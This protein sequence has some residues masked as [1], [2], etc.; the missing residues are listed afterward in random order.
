MSR[1]DKQAARK[2]A[3]LAARNAQIAAKPI[4]AAVVAQSAA[5]LARLA[6]ATDDDA[7]LSLLIEG[8]RHELPVDSVLPAHARAW[9]QTVRE[10]LTLAPARDLTAFRRAIEKL[11]K[12][13]AAVADHDM[14]QARVLRNALPTKWMHG[15]TGKLAQ[16]LVSGGEEAVQHA[17]LT[18][19]Q[20][21]LRALVGRGEI[22][23][24]Q[25]V[26]E[27]AGP[28]LPNAQLVV[29]EMR[30]Q[31]AQLAADVKKNAQLKDKLLQALA[32]DDFF[33]AR[34]C[35]ETLRRSLPASDEQALELQIESR[36]GPALAGKMLPPGVQKLKDAPAL[37]AIAQDRLI[38]VQDTIWFSVNL[39][40]GGLQP[41]ALPAQWPILAGP[42]C[43]L[44]GAGG[45]V[46]LIGLSLGQ[47]I[48][49]EQIP[50]QVP[51]IMRG[52]ALSE[53]LQ[54]DDLLI[55][56][57]IPPNGLTWNLLSRNS[58][59]PQASHLATYTADA[60]MLH[61]RRKTAPT[62]MHLCGI[63]GQDDQALAVALPQSREYA[64]A[65]LEHG[66]PLH[67]ISAA[68]LDEPIVAFRQA[69]A[70]PEE[71]RIYASYTLRDPF[72][73]QSVAPPS[74]L[75]L[76]DG[77]VNFVSSDLRK[78]FAPTE[79]LEIDGAWTLDP[80]AG[81]LWYAAL[82][83]EGEQPR[84]ALLLGVQ[85][86]NLRPDRPVPLPGMTRILALLPV[87]DG[88]VAVCRTHTDSYALVRAA[89][90]EQGNL[91]LTTTK[92]PL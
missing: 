18:A 26:L 43:R 6:Q 74:L 7:I 56:G 19:L 4:D 28:Q 65:V 15:P 14:G 50:G 72:S 54:G 20:E 64:V 46:R 83:T 86:K 81:R 79:K 10:A 91:R 80:Q 67:K 22:A 58:K 49:I 53:L 63:V 42:F 61:S 78:R 77:K 66:V 90:G 51:K 85:A 84:D 8:A 62:W 37:W 16:L 87:A 57:Q 31:L 92:L 12:L 13:R 38:V 11:H 68:E 24:A 27:Q 69:I 70:W 21:Q 39:A 33:S 2:Q 1:P 71:N 30:E 75:V 82:A 17:A 55:G 89:M 36:A 29:R 88:V 32:Q 5:A 45:C 52:V 40:T 60:Q 76:R 47:F 48:E 44:E 25:T 35:F 73:D 34:N 23:M 59:T 3:E 41:C 9:A